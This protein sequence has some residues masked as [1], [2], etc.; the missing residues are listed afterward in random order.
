MCIRDSA[1][2]IR[3]IAVASY[4]RATATHQ[5]DAVYRVNGSYQNRSAVPALAR[6]GV[7][8][9]VH[10]VDEVHVRQ[11]RQPEEMRGA[12]RE[13]GCRVTRWIVR[14]DV[15]LRLDDPSAGH[16]ASRRALKDSAE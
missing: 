8:A 6:D 7:E 4:A 15:R 12:R 14:T 13:S 1:R 16:A 11:S 5:L 3:E 9:P 2:T 10:A